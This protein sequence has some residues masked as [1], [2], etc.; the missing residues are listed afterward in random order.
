MPENNQVLLVIDSATSSLR[1]GLSL[2]DGRLA[3]LESREHLRHAEFIFELIDQVIRENGT[4][5]SA[6]DGI[7][8][9]IGPGSFT[10]LRVGMAAAKGLAAALRIPLFGVS[11]YAALA[12][13]I[14]RKEGKA[15]LLIPSRR[16]E[17]YIGQIGSPDF[18]DNSVAVVTGE[19]AAAM[20]A[21]RPL[22][23]VD[24]EI[25]K[26]ASWPAG[27]PFPGKIELTAD[28]LLEPGRKRF[29]DGRRDDI[30]RLEPLYV[31]KFVARK[32]HE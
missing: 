14:C 13:R 6:L 10:G 8:V 29:R 15:C 9:G 12:P 22:L 3:V 1:I 31:Q 24:F 23:A 7:I 32:S 27:T 26:A 2:P 5:K 20:A 30:A 16:D 17:F 18:N 21:G 25:N 19:E 4:G 28:D 11:I